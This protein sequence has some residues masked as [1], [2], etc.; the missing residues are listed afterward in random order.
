MRNIKTFECG[1]CKG[2]ER[3]VIKDGSFKVV[4]FPAKV[5]LIPLKDGF[6]LF[7]CGYPGDFEYLKK[8]YFSFKLYSMLLPTVSNKDTSCISQLKKMGISP[9]EIKYIFISHFH[10]DH[11]GGLKDFPNTKFICSQKEYQQVKISKSL[12]AIIARKF[13]PGDF[14]KRVLFIEDFKEEFI[15]EEGLIPIHLSGHTDNQYGLLCKNHKTL[16]A[17]DSAWSDKAYIENKLPPALTMLIM[18]DKKK[19]IETINL[20]VEMSKENK[21]I[22]SHSEVNND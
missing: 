9:D 14:E 1:Y 12:T 16:L 18:E 19:Y 10:A 15:I 8:K 3:F 5:A 21:I 7:D 4:K 22:L 13:L 11:A 20:L 2:V 6:M 17:A